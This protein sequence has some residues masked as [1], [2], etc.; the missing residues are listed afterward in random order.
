MR[1]DW[2]RFPRMASFA[3]AVRMAF[4]SGSSSKKSFREG[5]SIGSPAPE[6]FPAGAIPEL[7]LMGA[8]DRLGAE[9]VGTSGSQESMPLVAL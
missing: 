8:R 5:C 6:L 4:S 9:L 7:P 2:R 1:T 3:R